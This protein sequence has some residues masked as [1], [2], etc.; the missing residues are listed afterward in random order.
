MKS[1][2]CSKASGRRWTRTQSQ[3][4]SLR[5]W[6]ACLVPLA[7]RPGSGRGCDSGL[8]APRPGACS[9]SQVTPTRTRRPAGNSSNADGG[10][11]ARD[12]HP[13]RTSSLPS[14]A[15]GHDAWLPDTG[16]VPD[17]PLIPRTSDVPL[18]FIEGETP[19]FPQSVQSGPRRTATL[20]RT[21]GLVAVE[22]EGALA[23]PPRSHRSLI[24]CAAPRAR[25]T[26]AI[27]E[28]TCQAND[29]ALDQDN[30]MIPSTDHAGTGV[31][32]EDQR[33]PLNSRW[34]SLSSESLSA[35][36]PSPSSR[37]HLDG[38]HRQCRSQIR[39]EAQGTHARPITAEAG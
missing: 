35:Q 2:G 21:F 13:H 14:S 37:I 27:D 22:R 9:S 33:R 38:Y 11:I 15:Q 26:G 25:A 12:P 6:R 16:E 10:S 18:H 28:A 19:T 8:C 23:G 20:V 24:P 5:R 1:A 39:E 29:V 7:S 3:Q 17:H 36:R 31:D 34:S 32:R 4:Q 30:L